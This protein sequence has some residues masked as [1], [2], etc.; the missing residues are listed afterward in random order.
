VTIRRIELGET[1]VVLRELTGHADGP[2]VALFGGV[3]GDELEGI[4]AVRA[5]VARLSADPSVWSGRVLAVAVANPP[6]HE[7]GSRTSPIDDGNLARSFPGRADGPITERIADALSKQVIHPADLLIDLHSAG[8]KYAMPFFAGFSDPA[9]SAAA[10]AFG[11][12]LI[13]AHDTLNPGRSLTTASSFGVS[14]IYVEG[15]GGG[16]LRRSE[17]HGYRDGV[18]RVL[19]LLGM[20]PSLPESPGP[21][22]IMRGGDGDVD[23]SVSANARGWCVTAVRAGD[24]V[25]QGDL[26]AEIIDVNALTVQQI[27][28]PHDGTVMMLRRRAE[29]E[30]GDGIVMLGPVTEAIA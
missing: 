21:Q 23:S 12:P 8:L 15:G 25:R 10:Q 6:A 29:V 3:H 19:N 5:V 20:H 7:A 26:V 22:R 13:W 11:A 28:A 2:T 30:P 16:A 1:T 17:L 18:L 4:A 9:G 27:H 24:E 14:S